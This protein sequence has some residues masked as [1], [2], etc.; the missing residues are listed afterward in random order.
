MKRYMKTFAWLLIPFTAP[1]VTLH[2]SGDTYIS[3]SN[4]TLNF[5]NSPTLNVSPPATD[6][7]PVGNIALLQFDLSPLP[8]GVAAAN[9]QKATLTIFVNKVF[10]AGNLYIGEF[11]A[12]WQESTLTYNTYG[13]NFL[14]GLVISP[15]VVTVSA[16]DA[17]ITADITFMVQDWLQHPED[18]SSL[19]VWDNNDTTT[20]SLDSKEATATSHAATI[21]VT[22]FPQ[23]NCQ[24]GQVVT[25]F[26]QNGNPTCAPPLIGGGCS[27]GAFVTGISSSG[28]PTC[29]SAG[30]AAYRRNGT[31]PEPQGPSSLPAGFRCPSGSFMIGFDNAG[32][33]LCGNH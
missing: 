29:S 16:S 21:D 17:Y 23:G 28:V 8:A 24:V 15:R 7:S 33:P 12:P 32:K 4:P 9:I 13:S 18:G 31:P 19:I 1:A 5:G 2:V 14:L 11:G 3:Q 20:V 10:A 27:S 6:G 30:A 26:D 22:L 25:G